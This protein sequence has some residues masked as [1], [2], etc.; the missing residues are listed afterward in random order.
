MQHAALIRSL[1]L[2][3]AIPLCQVDL[4][5]QPPA[6]S[7]PG[8][9][10]LTPAYDAP[11]PHGSDRRPPT[12]GPVTS[13]PRTRP[14]LR[15]P[16]PTPAGQS[17]PE[18]TLPSHGAQIHRPELPPPACPPE[19][20]N[21][22]A[23]EC[24]PNVICCADKNCNLVPERS[25]PTT[26]P[27]VSLAHRS[28]KRW[29]IDVNGDALADMAF[30]FQWPEPPDEYLI[31]NWDGIGGDNIGI[32]S[33]NRF[34]LDTDFDS[35]TIEVAFEFG[36]GKGQYLV[37]DWD[38]DGD[39]NLAIRHG[40]HIA[41]DTNFNALVDYELHW[42]RGDYEDQY[43]VG[44][45]DGDGDD[46]LAVRRHN[47]ILMSA[48]TAVDGSSIRPDGGQTSSTDGI[49]DRALRFGLGRG[50]DAYLVGDWN[51]DG[52]DDIAVKRGRR[53]ILSLDYD[54]TPDGEI[55]LPE[56]A[57]TVVAGDW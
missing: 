32:R 7:G 15:D 57:G 19:D 18:P 14:P 9:A 43:L 50:E 44:D 5:F 16:H 17:H 29:L 10:P 2:L 48:D 28:G 11:P 30:V 35:S 1:L 31:G 8:L 21:P 3:G 26:A 20:P 34:Y 4:P 54:E 52:R 6:V 33:G 49:H 40:N 47:Q 23:G 42:G 22:C 27:C 46:D 45:W 55:Q 51:Q 53:M 41:L 25:C 56:S 38:G 37:G 36:D 13:P 39:D 24:I 12:A